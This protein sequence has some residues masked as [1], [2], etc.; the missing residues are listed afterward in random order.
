MHL[1]ATINIAE[2]YI[3]SFLSVLLFLTMVFGNLWRFKTH[4]R[5]SDIMLLMLG[6]S[7]FSCIIDPLA[8]VM[9]GQTGMLA[10]VVV[11]FGNN[12][13]YAACI[14]FAYSW[15][16]FLTNHLNAPL[17]KTHDLILRAIVAAGLVLLVVNAFVPL[18]FS[19]SDTNVYQREAMY[20]VYLCAD[21]AIIFDSL[22]VYI[23]ARR[24]S[25]TLKYFPVEA[26]VVPVVVGALAQAVAGFP[27]TWPCIT[28]A[29]AG[30]LFSLQNEI[31][32]R[33]NLTGLYNRFYLEDF[34]ET[35]KD[36]RN[37]S[38]TAM[39]LDMNGFKEIN[40][41]HGH[42]EGDRALRITAD[43]LRQAVG[44]LGTV[45]RYAG[46]EFVILLNTQDDQRI[47]EYVDAIRGQL[48]AFNASGEKPYQ[49]SVSLG[50]SKCDLEHQTID[51]LLHEIDQRM[52]E[53][54]RRFYSEGSGRDRRKAR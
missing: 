20:W 21:F 11:F 19:L 54:K 17:G 40:D 22:V 24:T 8:T 39:M 7:V 27:V 16:R 5:E 14:V 28:I 43:L 47:Q 3:L 53:D 1:E 4:T 34:A 42:S 35:L 48:A 12:W 41:V 32:F 45:V 30:V 50:H 49:L 29:L 6:V 9:S 26:F 2:N 25:G 36:P 33:D 44:G 13:L 10:W 23:K 38:F 15:M 18:V 37:G 31:L 46:D 51:E 52:Y